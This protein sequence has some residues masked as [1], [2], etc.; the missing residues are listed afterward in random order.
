MI[1][2]VDIDVDNFFGDIDV[3]DCNDDNAAYCVSQRLCVLSRAWEYYYGE[4]G[5]SCW[6]ISSL[7]FVFSLLVL[8]SF[9]KGELQEVDTNKENKEEQ[10]GIG[11]SNMR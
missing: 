1:F 8:L 9:L 6:L 10:V 11:G 3:D 5:G 2:L 4:S 7:V